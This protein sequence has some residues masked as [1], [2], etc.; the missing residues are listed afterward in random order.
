MR[1]RPVVLANKIRM[2]RS[3]HTGT[4]VIV[5]GKDDRLFCQ[6]FFNS[7][8]CNIVVAENKSNVCETIC[9]L[10]KDEFSGVVGLVDADFDHIERRFAISSNI[11]VTELHDLECIQLQS[12]GF[13]SLLV[14]YGSKPKLENF[15]PDIR[16]V[17]I[18]AASPIGYLRLY[19]ERNGISLRFK[20]MN[21]SKFIDK[22]TL[23][24]DLHALISQVKNR[25]HNQTISEV[26]LADGVRE[27]EKSEYDPWQI[28]TGTDILN[29]LS[30]GLRHILG[31]NNAT[32][33]QDVGL[34]RSL[35]LACSKEDFDNTKLKQ[36][37]C[38]W[39]A[40]NKSYRIFKV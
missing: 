12:K 16:D 8:L 9:I 27:L 39:E 22:Q 1:R 20:G 6:Q 19:S 2:Q 29:I 10:D 36:R 13:E 18:R 33:V 30:I 37:F 4:F 15:A 11:I 35:R 32:D 17:L 26:Q 34:R 31:N 38:E 3:Q 21:Y 23:S 5:E 28:C 40:R 7:K 25:S 24:I 14:E